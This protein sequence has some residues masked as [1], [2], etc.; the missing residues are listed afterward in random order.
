M[1]CPHMEPKQYLHGKR[2]DSACCCANI[3]FENIIS[4]TYRLSVTLNPDS[5]YYNMHSDKHN[6]SS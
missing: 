1:Y 3:H 5:R 6:H 2:R 4:P